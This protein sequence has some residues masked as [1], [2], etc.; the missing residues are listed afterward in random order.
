METVLVSNIQKFSLDDG[1]GI[2]TTVFF[3]GCNLSCAWCHNPECISQYPTLQ[4]INDACSGCRHC[5]DVCAHGVHSFKK[6]EHLI[7]R[8]LCQACETCCR[9]CL[10]DALTVNGKLWTRDQLL[11]VIMQDLDFYR[12]TGGGVTCSGGEPMLHADFVAELLACCKKEALSTA[13]DTAGNVPFSE[14]E[15]VLPWTDI[16]L[17]DIKAFSSEIHKKYTG[18]ENSRILANIRLLKEHHATVYVRIP[19]IP[20]VNDSIEEQKRIADFL[21]EVQPDK[22][23]LLPYHAYG[24][25]KYISSGISYRLSGLLPPTP[26]TME[27]LL[28]IFLARGL[29]AVIS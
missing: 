5:E 1:P 26:K 20:G 18:C 16:F 14:Y 29:P 4:F 23:E 19:V 3:K 13:V 11:S 10:Q 6:K 9:S 17:Y 15:K 21:K 12:E 8:S 25:G 2:R 24:T 27:N 22:I 28:L 7:N